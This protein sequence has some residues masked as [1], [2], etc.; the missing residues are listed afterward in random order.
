MSMA[1]QDDLPY[2]SPAR[3]LIRFFLKSRDQWKAKCQRAKATVKRLENRVRFLEKSKDNWKAKTKSLEAANAR[4]KAQ[5]EK[6]SAPQAAQA[7]GKKK[8]RNSPSHP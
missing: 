1:P 3:K 6:L 5:V 4:L 8:S 2:T 7:E